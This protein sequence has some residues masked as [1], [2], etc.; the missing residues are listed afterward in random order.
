MPTLVDPN[1]PN[2]QHA[3][4]VMGEILWR[5]LCTHTL[6]EIEA[7]RQQAET[8]RQMCH[9]LIERP[10]PVLPPGREEPESGGS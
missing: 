5:Y 2:V 10:T 9:R 1:N 6:E 3:S 4:R 8:H 7:L